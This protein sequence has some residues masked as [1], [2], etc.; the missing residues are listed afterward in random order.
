MKKHLYSIKRVAD[1]IPYAKNS[2]THSEQQVAQIAASIKEFGFTNPVLC[3]EED[4][5]IA[6]HGRL[7][8]AQKLKMEEVPAVI[9]AGLLGLSGAAYAFQGTQTAGPAGAPAS[10]EDGSI[11]YAELSKTVDAK[12]AK[13]A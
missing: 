13:A 2:R 12:K 9:V 7:L 1:L 10:L 11:L 6:G 4:V 3:D 5:L 8:A